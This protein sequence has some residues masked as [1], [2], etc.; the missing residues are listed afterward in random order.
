LITGQV[1]K[2]LGQRWMALNQKQL[3]LYEAKAAEEKNR[4]KDD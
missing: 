4:Y 2:V 3:V 1:G